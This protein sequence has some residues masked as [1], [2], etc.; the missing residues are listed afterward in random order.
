VTVADWFGFGAFIAFRA[1]G[2]VQAQ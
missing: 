2:F 1:A